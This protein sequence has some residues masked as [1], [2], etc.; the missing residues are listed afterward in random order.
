MLA[1]VFILTCLNFAEQSAPSPGFSKGLLR[2]M[3]L[4]SWIG[5]C[6]WMCTNDSGSPSSHKNCIWLS[7]DGFFYICRLS[8]AFRGFQVSLSPAVSSWVAQTLNGRTKSVLATVPDSSF[9]CSA[10]EGGAA[11]GRREPRPARASRPAA[12]SEI[13]KPNLAEPFLVTEQKKNI[14]KR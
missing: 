11:L 10:P 5:V 3:R 6:V 8:M 7:T 12:G 14:F 9:R 2:K 13:S 1:S 4:R